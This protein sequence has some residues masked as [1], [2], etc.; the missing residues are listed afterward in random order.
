[1]R[2]CVLITYAVMSV[3]LLGA[4]SSTKE[5]VGPGSVA[6]LTRT[7]STQ[8]RHTS[9]TARGNTTDVTRIAQQRGI[10]DEPW[11]S[12]AQLEL[13]YSET[14]PDT[15]SSTTSRAET[16]ASRQT[17][18]GGNTESSVNLASPETTANTDEATI[19]RSTT[20][21]SANTI[22]ISQGPIVFY[23]AAVLCAL[24]AGL[25]WLTPFKSIARSVVLALIAVG[26]AAIGTTIEQAPWVM[27]L[28]LVAVVAIGGW[29][30]YD[31]HR[32][33]LREQLAKAASNGGIEHA[34]STLNPRQ[35]KALRA[36]AAR[37][38][39]PTGG[40]HG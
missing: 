33:K 32:L 13:A 1:M 30:L 34:T 15:S 2:A 10:I 26:L 29:W 40:D 11:D 12:D 4:C 39:P 22:A 25:I 5:T 6:T 16:T 27:Y 9:L 23:G 7:D 21:G 36:E 28:G 38:T 31:G 24:G 14:E 8:G 19:G 37:L 18:R 3:L 35:A 17:V 20:T